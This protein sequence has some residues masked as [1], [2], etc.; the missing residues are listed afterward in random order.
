MDNELDWNDGFYDAQMGGL[1]RTMTGD[2]YMG[3]LAGEDDLSND[4]INPEMF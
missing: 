3:Y 1:P 4:G 2:Y